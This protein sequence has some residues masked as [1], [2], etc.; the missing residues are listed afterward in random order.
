MGPLIVI[1]VLSIELMANM[2]VKKSSIAD[3]LGAVRN[4]IQAKR[5]LLHFVNCD[6]PFVLSQVRLKLEK[7]FEVRD[8][9][10]VEELRLAKRALFKP[11]VAFM[12]F[13]PDEAEALR[14]TMPQINVIVLVNSDQLSEKLNVQCMGLA[15]FAG[16]DLTEAF[17]RWLLSRGMQADPAAIKFA[18]EKLPPLNLKP[19]LEMIGFRDN[20]WIS[21]P[22]VEAEFE[23]INGNI[24]QLLDQLVRNDR[25]G[26]MAELDRVLADQ[27][28]H[29]VLAS[30][31]TNTQNLMFCLQ[32][33][34]AGANYKQV[35]EVTGKSEGAMKNCMDRVRQSWF[36]EERLLL[37][38]NALVG[39]T[40]QLR[41][42]MPEMTDRDTLKFYLLKYMTQSGYAGV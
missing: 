18:L 13:D 3:V 16:E 28:P 33:K 20:F 37:L 6:D 25:F 26:F 30:L 42:R 38:Y 1:E 23:K 35:A 4:S 8:L 29:Q 36:S 10:N 11:S 5:N 32:G 24:F 9:L 17:D 34:K 27:V 7:E 19:T 41:R 2:K 15:A 39:L 22:A 31:L 21:L 14:A 40:L 12:Y